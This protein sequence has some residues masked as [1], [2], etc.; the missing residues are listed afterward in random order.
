MIE[1]DKTLHILSYP[2]EDRKLIC[3]CDNTELERLINYERFGDYIT[4]AVAPFMIGAGTVVIAEFVTIV[5][6]IVIH[7]SGWGLNSRWDFNDVNSAIIAASFFAG[8]AGGVDW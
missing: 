2:Y 5:S 7:Y 1:E 4:M 3:F 6:G 8:L